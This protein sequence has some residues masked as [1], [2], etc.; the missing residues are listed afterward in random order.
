MLASVAT[1][2]TAQAYRPF[3]T[4]DAGWVEH[5]EYMVITL[6]N[7]G[8]YWVNA[9]HTYR[10]TGDSVIG[11]V[12]WNKLS[13]YYEET[14]TVMPPIPPGC[15]DFMWTYTGS[16]PG[17]T[18][19]IRQDT[20]A[21]KVYTLQF[22]FGEQ[23]LYDFN[24]GLGPYP[25]TWLSSYLYPEVEV[26]AI[27]SV[28][29]GDG[30]RKRWTL[31][32][33]DSTGTLLD[34]AYAH[35]IDGVGSTLGVLTDLYQ[36]NERSDSLVCHSQGGLT[37]YPDA[38][39]TCDLSASMPAITAS[40]APHITV[41]PNPSDGLFTVRLG[42]KNGPLLLRAFT[43]TGALVHEGRSTDGTLRL[44]APPGCYLLHVL[45]LD[46]RWLGAQRLTK[47]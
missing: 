2:A 46:G 26:V 10:F 38:L 29:L 16:G 13:L 40:T 42:E 28:E 1:F 22:W 5:H 41:Y 17:G 7:C 6:G 27:D 33:M 4:S 39:T 31:A 11:G 9:D 37:I 15:P 8:A 3:P 36:Q 14:G 45:D 25:A 35:I 43:L 20:A 21:R 44:D 23:V 24:M 19:L 30:W 12:T 34:S 18:V 32:L 47:F